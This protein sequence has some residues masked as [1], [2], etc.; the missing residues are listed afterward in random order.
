MAEAEP[1]DSYAAFVLTGGACQGPVRV[2][3]GPAA[4]V[5]DAIV[6]WRKGVTRGTGAEAVQRRGEQLRAAVWDPVQSVLG[7]RN[8][9]RLVPDGL[10]SRLP[11]SALPDGQ[12]YLGARF[13][14]SYLGAAGDLARPEGKPGHGA[15]VVGGILYDAASAPTT[16]APQTRSPPRGGL[17]TFAFLPGTKAEAD[18]VAR[19][20]GT[21]VV[22]LSGAEATENRVRALLPGKR[23]VHIATHG[24]FAASGDRSTLSVAGAETALAQSPLL[25][26]GLVLA[27]GA[28][29][30]GRPGGDDGLLTAE[31]VLGLDLRGVQLV[32]LSACETGLGEVEDGE[33]VMGM[34]RAF[35]LAGADT[36]LL[37]LWKVPDVETRQLMAGFY[38]RLAAGETPAAALQGAQVE[39][40]ERLLA[41]RG[42]A[43]VF[44]WAAFVA[45]GG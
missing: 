4:P 45:S 35:A 22:Q 19:S 43:P 44:L 2:E 42:E 3:L 5:D 12:G 8:R 6:R 18:E 28:S 32:V 27:G 23:V 26:T 36:L 14:F 1:V 33:G 30:T 34:R 38:A 41:E 37:S 39:Q 11:F 25:R 9:V 10:L 13:V 20:L 24:F 21:G 29:A 7:P 16:D 17:P 15:L 31:E 40:I